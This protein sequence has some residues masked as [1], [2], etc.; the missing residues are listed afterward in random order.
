MTWAV[1]GVLAPMPWSSSMIMLQLH[2]NL[3]HS[4]G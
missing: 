1:W 3:C 4:F 2:F